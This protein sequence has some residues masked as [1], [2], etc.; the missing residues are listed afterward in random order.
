MAMSAI[1]RRF[2][3][4]LTKAVM[5]VVICLAQVMPVAC[6]EDRR[7]LMSINCTIAATFLLSLV[8]LHRSL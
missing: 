4:T 1:A 2:T 8:K 5:V 3:T 6:A 7:W